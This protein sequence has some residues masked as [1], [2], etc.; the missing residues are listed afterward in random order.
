MPLRLE[1]LVD[2]LPVLVKRPRGQEGLTAQIT[3]YRVLVSL[4]VG[5][6]RGLAVESFPTLQTQRLVP[7]TDVLVDLEVRQQRALHSESSGAVVTF[8]GFLLGVYSDVSH[9][10]TRFLEFSAKYIFLI[11]HNSA[12]NFT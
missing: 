1:V 12:H 5:L 3:G 2:P 6:V 4:H 11:S 9:K 7:V 10:I 8:E